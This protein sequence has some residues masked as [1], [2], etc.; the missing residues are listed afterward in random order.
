VGHV[1][2]VVFGS[3]HYL[4]QRGHPRTPRDLAK[5]DIV[6]IS[7][8]LSPIGWRFRVSGRDRAV[9]LAPR[10][11]VTDVESMLHAVRAGR[12]I[13]RTLSYQVAD[14]FSSGTLVRLLTEFERPPR[15]VHVVVPSARHMLPTVRA[16]LD[17]AAQ[18]LHALRA[19]H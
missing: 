12:G 3:P 10:F 1:R 5:H 6:F 13:G 18:G 9:R 16:F 19:I 8:R 15:P 17:H 14:D 2:G 11:L 4:A 7:R